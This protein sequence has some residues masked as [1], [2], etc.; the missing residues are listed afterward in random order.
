[1]NVIIFWFNFDQENIQYIN[2]RPIYKIIV[3]NAGTYITIFFSDDI[4]L[5]KQS[6]YVSTVFHAWP[7]YIEIINVTNIFTIDRTSSKL[8]WTRINSIY[9]TGADKLYYLKCIEFRS[10][11]EIYSFDFFYFYKGSSIFDIMNKSAWNRK[12]ILLIS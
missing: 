3:V 9:W 6:Y 5:N 8:G 1:M 7:F 12:F 10:T 4:V 2:Y 11:I